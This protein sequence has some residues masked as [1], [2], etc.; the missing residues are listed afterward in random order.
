MMLRR[1]PPSAYA[2]YLASIQRVLQVGGVPR[3]AVELL[4]ISPDEEYRALRRASAH[5][6]RLARTLKQQRSATGAD[7]AKGNPL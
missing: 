7:P 1:T 2:A 3:L 5:N 6:N 4:N